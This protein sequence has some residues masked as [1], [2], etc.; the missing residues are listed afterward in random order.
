M[1]PTVALDFINDVSED[2]DTRLSHLHYLAQW[3]GDGGFAPLG[4]SLKHEAMVFAEDSGQIR[5]AAAVRA[6][7]VNADTS[8]LRG[9]GYGARR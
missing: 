4:A 6:A 7:L 9:L 2:A 1:D 5:L 3:L 8:G